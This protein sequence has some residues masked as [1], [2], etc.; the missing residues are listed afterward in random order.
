MQGG[1][2][3]RYARAL[4]EIGQEL[5]TT[6]KLQKDLSAFSGIYESNADLRNVLLNPS[7]GLEERKVLVKTLAKRLM[8]SAM[9]TNFLLLLLD[10]D[11]IGVLPAIAEAFQ[12]IADEK[13]GNVRAEV[14]TSTALSLLQ[15]KKM[16]DVLSKVTGKN[17]ILETKL[18]PTLIGGAVTRIAGKVYDGSLSTQLRI[19]KASVTHS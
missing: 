5:K 12:H 8:Y 4:L 13:A 18:D 2:S 6:A 17:V 1:V 14:T 16:K 11:R 3:I 7:I 10:K 19:I 15:K 9:M